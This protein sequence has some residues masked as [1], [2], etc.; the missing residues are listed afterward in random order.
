MEPLK[1]TEPKKVTEPKIID[2][3]NELPFGVN[4]IEKLND[5]LAD[6]QRHNE[7]LNDQNLKLV[8][9]KEDIQKLPLSP[10]D[11][12]TGNYIWLSIHTTNDDF[13]RKQEDGFI[14]SMGEHISHGQVW[15]RKL[16]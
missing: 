8:Q 11:D 6:V 1:A 13:L 16:R 9:F 14:V 5:E 2:H 7:E 4:V 15:F 12:V 3:Y 10:V